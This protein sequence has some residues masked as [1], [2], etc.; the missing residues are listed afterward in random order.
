[1]ASSNLRT[2]LEIIQVFEPASPIVQDANNPLVLIGVNRQIV[3]HENTGNFIGGQENDPFYFPDL[4]AG[5]KVEQP[6]ASEE[7]LRPHV[8][9]SG[10]YGVSEVTPIYNFGVDPPNI[11]LSPTLSAVF[12]IASGN[13]GEYSSSSGKFVDPSA[14]FIEAEVAPGDVIKVDDVDAFLVTNLVSDTEIDVSRI[15]KAD[16]TWSGDLSAE[17]SNGDRIFTDLGYDFE[18]AGVMIGDLMTVKG[19][20]ILATGD[21]IDFSAEVVG[22][23]TITAGTGYDFSGAGVQPP[24]TG[25][26]YQV[27]IIWMQDNDNPPDWYP[28]LKVSANVTTNTLDAVNLITTPAYPGPTDAEDDKVFEIYH[29]TQIDLTGGTVWTDA[30]GDWT[31]DGIPIAG[32]RTFSIGGGNPNGI[33]FSTLLTLSLSRYNL[34]VHGI[35]DAG[36]TTNARPIFKIISI[37]NPTTLVVQNWDPDRPQNSTTGTGTTWEIWDDGGAVIMGFQGASITAEGPGGLLA[38]NERLFTSTIDMEVAGVAVGDTVFSAGG[39]AMFEV[40]TVGASGNPG[41]PGLLNQFELG[42]TNLVPGTPPPSWNDGN[43]PFYV[44][45]VTEAI[46]R[47]TRVLDANNLTVRNTMASTPPEASAF[48]GLLYSITVADS[49]SSLNYTIEK[50]VSGANLTGDVLVTY[51]ARRNDS[52][53]QLF[54]VKA[55][56]WESLLGQA[57]P[58]N[59]LALA[60]KIGT[61]NSNYPLWVLQVPNDL[62]QDWTDTL[63]YLK[64]NRYYILCPLTQDE[65]VLSAY[66]AHVLAQSTPETKRDRILFQSHLFERIKTRTTGSTSTFTKT[67]TVTTITVTGD[68]SAYGVLVG[69]VMKGTANVSGTEYAFE[70]RIITLITGASSI[71]TVV[72][73]NGIGGTPPVS[74]TITAWTIQSKDLTDTQFAMEMAEYA[75]GLG[76]R[77]FRNVFPST[78]QV[79]FSDQTDPSLA[80]GLYGGGDV[81]VEVGGQY[82][83]AMFAAMRSSQKP[84]QALTKV[85]GTGIYKVLN[86]F[87]DFYGGDEDTNDIVLNGGNWIATQDTVGGDVSS[88]RAVTTDT[89]DIQ[90]L[91]DSVTVQVD[92]FARILRKQ[93]K[94]LLGPFNIE[95]TYFD[96]VS[97]NVQA[98]IDKI[99]IEDKDMKFIEFLDIRESETIIDTFE[100]DFNAD[101]F[102]SAAR[103]KVTIFV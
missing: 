17:D 30:N 45:D 29:Y 64:T 20:D 14:D 43:F 84:A 71:L 44:T 39:M 22:V 98:V 24:V 95:E 1:M 94:P 38:A 48:T 67:A 18:T 59:P 51:T 8:F 76:N 72:N 33:D 81:I 100:L 79:K 88:A 42:V 82:Q 6:S 32:Q 69:D 61:L 2:D 11:E 49:L 31:A 12:E 101:P 26:P 99:V 13:T 25:P 40:T 60:A 9:I 23:R 93:I 78:C 73:D 57:V 91:E 75:E 52:Y 68:L 7:E 10:R 90:K 35:N 63:N 37:T 3:W 70:A 77:R 27:D 87:G 96:M 16:P 54:T 86:P 21:G 89:S 80:S 5:S 28:A 46:M 92:N 50:T 55:D 85:M 34:V 19:W 47:V 103:A 56:D 66:R 83:A 4:I 41:Y 74:G 58:A 65:T 36:G 53:T 15:D 62:S 97:A 102:I